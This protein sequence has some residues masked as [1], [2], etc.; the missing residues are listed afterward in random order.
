MPR[1]PYWPP[2]R[3]RKSILY[4]RAQ[5]IVPGQVNILPDGLGVKKYNLHLTLSPFLVS[6]RLKKVWPLSEPDTFVKNNFCY[7]DY[8]IENL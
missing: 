3:C 7:F 4:Y 8:A 5:R 1:E 6:L 2:P